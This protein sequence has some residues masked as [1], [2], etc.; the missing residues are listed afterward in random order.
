MVD[1]MVGRIREE[2]QDQARVIA[3]GGLARR[4]A[5]ESSVIQEVVPFLTLEGLRMLYEKNRAPSR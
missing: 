1:S 2:L 4:I 3:T 5:E